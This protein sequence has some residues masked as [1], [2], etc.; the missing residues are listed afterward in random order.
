MSSKNNGKGAVK[1]TL[2]PYKLK[3]QIPPDKGVSTQT[4]YNFTQP[5]RT[6]D[7]AANQITLLKNANEYKRD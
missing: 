2:Q 1:S 4:E 6:K 3:E 7:K 5:M